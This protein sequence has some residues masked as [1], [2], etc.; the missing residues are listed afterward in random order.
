MSKRTISDSS[1]ILSVILGGG[2]GSRLSPLTSAIV[3]N[4]LYRLQGDIG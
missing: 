2:A 3:Q 1:E 4:Q